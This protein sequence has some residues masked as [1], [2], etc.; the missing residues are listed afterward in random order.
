MNARYHYPSQSIAVALTALAT[1]LTSCETAPHSAGTYTSRRMGVQ[2]QATIADSLPPPP[3]PTPT[4][5]VFQ[6]SDKVH[7]QILP[8]KTQAGKYVLERGDVLHVDYAFSGG[9]YHVLPGDELRVHF[10]SD[11]KLDFTAIVR[12]DGRVTLPEVA[13]MIAGGATAPEI[14]KAFDEKYSERLR[15]PMI[16]VTVV[17]SN[18]AM[19]DALRGDFLVRA[20]G[21]VALPFLGEITAGGRTPGDLGVALSE[22]ATRRF[23]NAL[24]FYVTS[25]VLA[26]NRV[27]PKTSLVGF[28]ETL[29]VSPEGYLVLPELGPIKALGLTHAELQNELSVRLKERYSNP[30]DLSLTIIASEARVVYVQ[31]EVGRA[32]IFPLTSGLTLLK[33]ITLAGGSTNDADLK[34]VVLIHYKT[35]V[36][37]VVY[38]TN[39]RNM[40]TQNK[41]SNDVLLSA[42]D[43]VFVPKSGVA[44]ANLFV[45]QYINRMLPFSRSVNYTFSNFPD[46][47]TPTASTPTATP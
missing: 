14:A 37:I 41:S 29:T 20:D 22:A 17:K 38:K 16:S 5:P 19:L 45:D 34:E 9:E 32:G 24:S 23:N 27:V 35:P 47:T 33:A 1:L 31:G 18:T 8:G 44:K 26:G 43:V 39:V 4:E 3:P 42:Q 25:E 11:P 2:A 40:I 6:A 7:V 21:M 28:D 10:A 12:P 15:N 13:E 46:S 36:D 30:V